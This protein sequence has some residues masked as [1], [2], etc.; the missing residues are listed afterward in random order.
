V[1]PKGGNVVPAVGATSTSDTGGSDA[2]QALQSRQWVLDPVGAP[3][4]TG[5]SD[6]KRQLGQDPVVDSLTVFQY[7]DTAIRDAYDVHIFNKEALDY[8]AKE[9]PFPPPKKGS[10]VK[11]YD[12]VA[13][14]LPKPNQAGANQAVPSAANFRKLAVYVKDGKVIQILERIDVVA[15]L[16][17]MAR[18]YG[19]KFPA[20][21]SPAQQAEFAIGVV[22]V[23]RTGQGNEPIRIRTMSLDIRDLGTSERVTLPDGAISGNLSFLRGRGKAAATATPGSDP[24]ATTATTS[25]SA[26]A[27][28]STTAGG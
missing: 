21:Q 11:R 2:L 1:S 5:A 17:D 28:T 7:V 22:N 8:K 4:V 25:A 9:D 13:P 24:S 6:P 14:F 19:V 15:R 16:K 18:I 3:S 27:S 12:L 20:G 26:S 23:L 10:G